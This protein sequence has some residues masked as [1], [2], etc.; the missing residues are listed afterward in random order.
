MGQAIPALHDEAVF[1][2]HPGFLLSGKA[3][4]LEGRQAQ[5]VKQMHIPIGPAQQG[6]KVFFLQQIAAEHPVVVAA[7]RAA[8]DARPRQVMRREIIEKKTQRRSGLG[9]DI[10]I[11]GKT[12]Q[13]QQGFEV[14]ATISWAIVFP[15]AITR[16]VIKPKVKIFSAFF[17]NFGLLVHL[18]KSHKIPDFHQ[19]DVGVRNAYHLVSGTFEAQGENFVE[20]FSGCW[21]EAIVKQQ[22]DGQAVLHAEFDVV[23]VAYIDPGFVPTPKDVAVTSARG[24]IGNHPG[25]NQF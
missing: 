25:L 23:A 22:F 21:R 15:V 19:V 13:Q 14:N 12:T 20:G 2:L 6:I 8:Q 5:L 3:N 10:G 24:G 7:V 1:A 16:Q 9:L 11:G 4:F 17:Q 18:P